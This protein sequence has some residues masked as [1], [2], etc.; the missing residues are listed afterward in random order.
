MVK[1]ILNID[2]R[3]ICNGDEPHEIPFLDKAMKVLQGIEYN[4]IFNYLIGEHTEK[5]YYAKACD[6]M[7][8]KRVNEDIFIDIVTKYFMEMRQNV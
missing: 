4:T 6:E 1:R 2:I 3:V 7:L 5:T 8:N